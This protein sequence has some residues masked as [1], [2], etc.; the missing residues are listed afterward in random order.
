MGDIKGARLGHLHQL[1]INLHRRTLQAPAVAAQEHP[2]SRKGDADRN[3]GHPLGCRHCRHGRGLSGFFFSESGGPGLFPSGLFRKV[4][5]PDCSGSGK[6]VSRTV[7]GLFG[8]VGVPDC[9]GKW[10]SRTVR[11]SGCPGLFGKV[12]VP[13][14]SGLSRTVRVPNCSA[15]HWGVS[16]SRSPT[17]RESCQFLPKKLILSHEHNEHIPTRH[18]QV[19]RG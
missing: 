9:S 11:E 3:R 13:D 18:A 7:R 15:S 6:W 16:S 5:V 2:G 10:V 19:L 8:K 12:G 17:N 4:G 1:G 14:C